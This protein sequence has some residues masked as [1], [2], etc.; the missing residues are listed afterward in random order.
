MKEKIID[1]LFSSHSLPDNIVAEIKHRHRLIICVHKEGWIGKYMMQSDTMLF[2]CLAKLRMHVF[3][4]TCMKICTCVFFTA[5]ITVPVPLY[6]PPEVQ[7]CIYILI[8][9]DTL[10]YLREVYT[11]SVILYSSPVTER[12][13]L[14]SFTLTDK[15]SL[16]EANRRM[17]M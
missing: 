15:N 14:S 7:T 5:S 3:A 9:I 2:L 1:T 10:L 12:L 11:L 16:T 17:L 13:T 6:L 4:N 8:H